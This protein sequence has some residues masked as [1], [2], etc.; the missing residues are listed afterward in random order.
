LACRVIEGL[1]TSSAARTFGSN[2]T[3]PNG[4]NGKK[5]TDAKMARNKTVRVFIAGLERVVQLIALAMIVAF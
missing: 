4:L 5:R 3:D 1:G 2:P